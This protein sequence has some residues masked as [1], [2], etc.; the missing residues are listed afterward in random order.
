MAV[1]ETSS[2][3]VKSLE[4]S[5]FYLIARIKDFPNLMSGEVKESRRGILLDVRV[6]T[7]GHSR[8]C[9][10]LQRRDARSGRNAVRASWRSVDVERVFLQCAER[11]HGERFLVRRREHNGRR[12]ARL[13]RLAPCGRAHAPA[14]ARLQAGKSELRCRRDQVI[15]L[16]ARE[17]EELAGHLRADDMQAE[18]L[19]TGIAT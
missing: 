1:L 4:I 15:A 10:C 2:E 17:H 12:D 11:D 14:I 18:V 6:D 16:L 19:G 3:E 9:P 5:G 13:V 8:V 7:R